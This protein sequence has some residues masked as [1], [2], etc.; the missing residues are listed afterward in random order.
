YTVTLSNAA[1]T[2]AVVTVNV[3][4]TDYTVNIAAGATSG[5]VDVPNTNGEDPYIDASKLTGTVT[6]LTGGNFEAVDYSSATAT[7]TIFD[8][9]V[10]SRDVWVK[11]NADSMPGNDHLVA[12]L[13]VPEGT[14]IVGDPSAPSGEF[15]I[16]DGMLYYRQTSTYDHHT[17]GGVPETELAGSVDV[18]LRDPSGRE[19]TYTVLVNIE[20]DIP[21]LI[22]GGM[23]S[24]FLSDKS[25]AFDIPSPV[26]LLSTGTILASSGADGFAGR[27]V[28]F[29][30]NDGDT[31]SVS[32]DDGAIETATLHL[33]TSED[34]REIL[35][36]VL[37]GGKTIFAA[38]V[39]NNGSWRFESFETF[40]VDHDGEQSASIR[41]PFRTEDSDGDSASVSAVV[42][43]KIGFTL[44]DGS[45]ISNADD[46]IIIPV[47]ETIGGSVAGGDVGGTET[48]IVTTPGE[49]YN[50]SII[51][52][53][54]G[55]MKYDRETGTGDTSST[56]PAGSRMEMAVEA[57]EAFF[58]NSIQNHDGDVHIC[59]AGFGSTFMGS[60]ELT[61]PADSTEEERMLVYEQFAGQ[62]ENWKNTMFSGSYSQGTNYEA[63]MQAVTD[64]YNSSAISGNGGTN[65]SFFLTDGVPTYY[66][67]GS[68]YSG[69][70]SYADK[71]S[72][73][74]AIS[75]FENLANAGGGVSV[76]AIGIGTESSLGTQAQQILDLLDNTTPTGSFG[77][78]STYPYQNRSG[79][80]NTDTFGETVLSS[81]TETVQLASRPSSTETTVEEQENEDGTITRITTSYS[82]ETFRWY[83]T[84][85]TETLLLTSKP[86]GEY[87]L[88]NSSDDLQAALEKGASYSNGVLNA[89][90]SDRI[91]FDES[92]SKTPSALIYGDVMNTDILLNKL[93]LTS[94]L[95]YGSGYA[96]FTYL[97]AH[98]EV[99]TSLILGNDA[100]WTA[101]DTKDYILNHVE[102]LGMETR[103][104]QITHS[105]GGTSTE[106]YLVDEH[107]HVFNPDGTPNSSVN[108][109][110]L[111]A[112]KGGHDTITGGAD[113]DIIYA[114]DGDDTIHGGEGNDV[115]YG[116]S[117]DDILYGE[118]GDDTLYGGLGSD[119][120]Y[121]GE[122]ND[123]LDG[124]LGSDMLYGEEGNDILVY[125][126]NDYLVDGGDGIDF[127]ISDQD[128]IS[129]DSVLSG[130][131]IPGEGP[132]VSGVEVLI[133]GKNALSLTGMKQLAEEYG[134]TISTDEA[135][136]EVMTLGDGWTKQGTDANGITTLTF[137]TGDDALTLET[138][139]PDANEA[140]ESELASA[141]Q[142]FILNNTNA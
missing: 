118:G 92:A 5:T 58:A 43:L 36:A 41:L 25:S 78:A 56:E 107:G 91:H 70:G 136:R 79:A 137:G 106:Y 88:V 62:L 46:D 82:R 6:G 81:E 132:V 59:L 52:D 31:I 32:I 125:D 114:Q 45:A 34:G 27:A 21:T 96:V 61:I 17:A 29:D 18:T 14:E 55:S 73:S 13:R 4:G 101:T 124:G 113:D 65:M 99:D 77:S 89:V 26:Q 3:G 1:Q 104:L 72:V 60:L 127:L 138:N 117:G 7:A 50:I 80:W 135:G 49:T 121:G 93:G 134:I 2:D 71:T 67:T 85:K 22:L 142:V 76:N 109:E 128:G 48:V 131:G 119:T 112:R 103:I 122:G 19:G 102:E 37:E 42:P 105:D 111:T 12:I 8:L 98:P 141:T 24:Q 23:H 63:G 87:D 51:L 120:L 110:D 66:G 33:S 47:D 40:T 140:T 16:E 139:I 68:S 57:L 69:G 100:S 94:V 115:L 97:E 74:H 130:T 35:T 53:L 83:K 20:D 11:D 54:S 116:G 15:L 39:D 75:A 10:T 129:M 9:P 86:T 123:Y 38:S 44:P 126:D 133:H 108:A 30:V 84:T 64:W 28:S 90:G 95:P